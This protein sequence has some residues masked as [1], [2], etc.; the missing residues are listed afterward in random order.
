MHAIK[1]V[2][3]AIIKAM[4]VVPI[5]LHQSQ[6]VRHPPNRIHLQRILF[7]LLSLYTYWES[8]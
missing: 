7:Y 4:L 1:K 5:I 2:M 8:R 3:L 6:V